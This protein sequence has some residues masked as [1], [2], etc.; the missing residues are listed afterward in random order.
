MNKRTEPGTSP[1]HNVEDALHSLFQTHQPDPRFVSRLERQ[2]I[3]QASADT[4]MIYRKRGLSNPLAIL[5]RLLAWASLAVLLVFVVSWSVNNLVPKPASALPVPAGSATPI[6]VT[7]TPPAAGTPSLQATPQPPTPAPDQTSPLLSLSS[8]REDLMQ[9]MMRPVW[10]AVQITG[11][12]T[13]YTQDQGQRVVYTQAWVQQQGGG[14]VLTS[15]ELPAAFPF[16][17]DI[18]ARWVW[19][20]DGSRLTIFNKALGLADPAAA[21]QSWT[22]HPLEKANPVLAML[23][24]VELGLRSSIPQAVE[25][26]TQAGRPALVIEWV[27]DRFWLDRETGLILRWQTTGDNGQIVQDTVIDSIAYSPSLPAEV[28]STQALGESQF[29]F[30]LS[31]PVDTSAWQTFGSDGMG[32]SI[33]HPTSWEVT[34]LDQEVRFQASEKLGESPELLQ[35]QVTV[36]QVLNPQ[37]LP[38]EQVATQGLDDAARAAFEFTQREVGG[39]TAY[40][41]TSLPSRSGALTVFIDGGSRYLSIELSPYHTQVP[42]PAQDTYAAVFEGMLGTLR[43]TTPPTTIPEPTTPGGEVSLSLTAPRGPVFDPVYLVLHD[44][45]LGSKLVRASV[46]C[47]ETASDC[48][49]EV[50]SGYPVTADT[51][52]VWSPDG[53][54]AVLYDANNARL[55]RFDAQSDAFAEIAS[56]VRLTVNLTPWSPD[57]SWIAASTQKADAINSTLTL[58]RPDGSDSRSLPS[59]TRGVNV[60]LGWL[61]SRTLLVFHE[62]TVAKGA[63]TPASASDRPGLYTVRIDGNSWTEF[64]LDSGWRKNYPAVSPDGQRIAF[65]SQVSGQ[66]VISVMNASG[67]QVQSLGAPGKDPVWSPDG[68]RI[69]S[70]VATETGQQLYV[71]GADGSGLQQLFESSTYPVAVWASD[72]DHVLVQTVSGQDFSVRWLLLSVSS[73]S[74]RKIT[75]ND[76]NA[77]YEIFSPS[78]P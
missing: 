21:S 53:S 4:D 75:V 70:V 32:F 2:L 42:W 77:N 15:D 44:S 19:V 41:T 66:T 74:A 62:A 73:G 3:E 25:E 5:S 59:E 16:T 6:I 20:S 78:L 48:V 37:S 11:H 40:A 14:R 28:L 76:P 7:A 64:S 33:Q 8:S 18:A 35:Y 60:P 47:L 72:S 54:T 69:L 45:E 30:D 36:R 34:V 63:E 68:Q 26:G 39:R 49:A 61:D 65:S 57:G 43:F 31:A 67:A 24:P 56:D 1:T 13:T 12:A 22:A 50:I 17:P 51:P 29:A 38:F 52:L 27:S 58:I 23:F 55:L 9:R 10:Q 71:V 46:T